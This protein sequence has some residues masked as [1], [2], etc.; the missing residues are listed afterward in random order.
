MT[1]PAV[2]GSG[3]CKRGRIVSP[4][5]SGPSGGALLSSPD[6]GQQCECDPPSTI[7]CHGPRLSC[8]HHFGQRRASSRKADVDLDNQFAPIQCARPR[9][10]YGSRLTV[11]NNMRPVAQT[12]H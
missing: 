4:A 10:P 2:H 7:Q 1:R 8:K 6:H 11:A 9:R 5:V 12:T 3:K